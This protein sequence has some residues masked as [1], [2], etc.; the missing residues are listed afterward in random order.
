[1]EIKDLAHQIARVQGELGEAEVGKADLEYRLSEAASSVLRNLDYTALGSNE[2][3]RKMGLEQKLRDDPTWAALSVSLHEAK[4]RVMRLASEL[5]RL[6]ELRRGEEWAI[7]AQLVAQ[8]DGLHDREPGSDPALDERM[9]DDR[10][11]RVVQYRPRKRQFKEVPVPT[12]DELWP[13][14]Q[15]SS[16]RPLPF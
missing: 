15:L 12:V 4:L 11:K 8:D 9:I 16:P 3:T 13:E 2:A 10:V 14:N 7:R 5:E 6:K 1:M